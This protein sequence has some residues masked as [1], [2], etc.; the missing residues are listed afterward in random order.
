MSLRSIRLSKRIVAL[1]TCCLGVLLAISPLAYGQS[2]EGERMVVDKII[3]KVDDYIILK[4]DLDKAYLDLMS[5][6]Q[7]GGDRVRCQ[8]LSDLV[9]T[10][11]LVA[12]AEID[13]VIVTEPEVEANLARRMNI[14]L[15]QI[16]GEEKVQ[17]IY[18][19]SVEEIRNDLRGDLRE[20]LTADRMESEVT[21]SVTVSPAEVKKFFNRIPQDSLPFFSTEVTVGQIVKFPE[22]TDEEKEKVKR[23]LTEIRSDIVN[24]EADFGVMARMYSEEPG[25]ERSGGNIGFFARGQ[26][27]PEYEAASLKMKPGEISMPVETQFGFHVI[28]LIE[29]RGNEFNTRHILIKPKTRPSDLKRS[30]EYL[31]SLRTLIVNDSIEFEE[32]AKEYSDDQQTGNSGG[33][34]LD[35]TGTPRVS[36]ENLDPTLFF[37]ID[38]MQVGDISEPIEFTSADGQTGMRIIYYKDKIAPHQANLKQDY[39]KI[40]LA[41][42]NEKK[43][44]ALDDWFEQAKKEVYIYIDP[45]YDQCGIMDSP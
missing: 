21:N 32:T 34:F 19:K 43:T 35:N 12:K 42:K 30:S 1:V 24:G 27:A 18:N 16:G 20:Q 25:A 23:Q 44:S 14:I 38:T 8:M 22:P 5:R 31:D 17:E 7:R 9:L 11:V 29:R 26:L 3:A 40:F 39:Q 6:G 13:S 15:S 4:S 37:T 28:Q 36:T 10:K 33:F 2:G 45:D 41:T